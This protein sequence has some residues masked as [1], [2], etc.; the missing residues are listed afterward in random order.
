MIQDLF[1]HLHLGFSVALSPTNLLVCLIGCLGGTLIGVLPGIGPVTT[2]A[3]MLPVTFYL[4]PVSGLIMLAGI[5]YGAQYGGS[6]TAILVNMPGETSAVVTALDGYAMAQQG[7]AGPALTTAALVSLFAGVVSTLVICLA[8]PPLAVIGKSF[9]APEYCALM[10]LGLIGAVVIANGS[11]LKA[12]AMVLV[13]LLLGIVGIDLNTGDGRFTFDMPTLMDGID[14]VPI[15]VGI[16]GLGEI[17]SK[18]RATDH[19]PVTTAR[20]QMWPT[21]EDVRRASPAAVRGTAVGCVIGILPGGGAALS[22]F[23]SYMVEKRVARDPS[24]LGKGAIEGVAAPEAANNAGAQTS[25]IPM[26]TL[27]IPGNAVMAVMVAALMIHGINPGPGVIEEKPDLFWGIVASMFIG[28]VMLVI[29]NL[30]L[31]GIWVSLLRIPYRVLYLA[32]IAFCAIGTYAFR[33]NPNDVLIAAMFGVLGYFFIV[34]RC[35]P[36]PLL[37]GFVLGPR[38]EDN[39]RSS[40][41]ISGGDPMIFVNRPISLGLFLATFALLLLVVLPSFRKTRE[42]AL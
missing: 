39:L 4:E 12:L 17:I 26:L 33:G 35:E 20:L 34:Y 21:R 3:L 7:R 22:A 2:I 8:A 18:L 5:F 42:E 30:P 40:M 19:R 1:Q 11:I 28:N 16:F 13:G 27:G 23:M 15:S 25:F 6:T 29:I 32:I 9:G 31:I 14:F 38:L 10:A 36:A 41:V 37:L 24:M